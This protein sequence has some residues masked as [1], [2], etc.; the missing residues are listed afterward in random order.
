MPMDSTTMAHAPAKMGGGMFSAAIASVNDEKMGTAPRTM[1]SSQ[2]WRLKDGTAMCCRCI[3]PGA[4]AK[5][6]DEVGRFQ[7]Q[8]SQN[9]SRREAGQPLA[10]RPA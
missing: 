3:E 8:H 5:T 10:P 6:D 4:D 2:C 7:R 9:C 1:I